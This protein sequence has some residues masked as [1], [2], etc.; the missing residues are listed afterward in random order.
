MCIYIS[1]NHNFKTLNFYFLTTSFTRSI[2][3]TCSSPLTHS[4]FIY[5]LLR[6]HPYLPACVPTFKKQTS[7]LSQNT[8]SYYRLLFIIKPTPTVF[9][10]I[11]SLFVPIH[12]FITHLNILIPIQSSL[13]YSMY[14]TIRFF[15]PLFQFYLFLSF[16]N[17][18][19]ILPHQFHS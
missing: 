12:L 1:T 14:I 6:S 11:Q 8:L 19:Y 4:Q 17:L 16:T 2:F 13:I 3:N 7:S 15:H 9:R 18:P 5:M 10:F